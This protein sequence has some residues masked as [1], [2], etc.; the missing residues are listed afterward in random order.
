[1]VIERAGELVELTDAEMNYYTETPL[2][3][4]LARAYGAG[5]DAEGDADEKVWEALEAI[6][7]ARGYHSNWTRKVLPHRRK[8][9]RTPE[10][11]A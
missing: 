5:D 7:K 1:M 10:L 2:K 4:L 6:R 3:T 9:Q 8:R 11:V